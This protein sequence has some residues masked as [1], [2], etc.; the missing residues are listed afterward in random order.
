M[1][2]HPRFHGFGFVGTKI[3][4]YNNVSFRKCF[5]IQYSLG[6]LSP[7]FREG[8]NGISD[9]QNQLSQRSCYC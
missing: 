9:V 6:C 3:A 8:I 2:T 1:A 7:D 5:D 4:S